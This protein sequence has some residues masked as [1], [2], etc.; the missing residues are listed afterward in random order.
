MHPPPMTPFQLALIAAA[1]TALAGPW[2]VR[3]TLGLPAAR[4]FA[5]IILALLLAGCAFFFLNRADGHGAAMLGF[6]ILGA[7]TFVAAISSY[8]AAR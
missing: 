1:I 8:F 4:I 5:G 2:E 7:I 6:V 3:A